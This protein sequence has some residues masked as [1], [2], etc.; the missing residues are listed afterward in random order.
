MILWL[1]EFYRIRKT[2]DLLLG[3]QLHDTMVCLNSRIRKMPD[4]LLGKQLHD[5]M[6]A[7]ILGYERYQ[8]R[9]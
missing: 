3:K 9:C 6:V 7:L 1:P 4:L 2:P 8:I 5:T